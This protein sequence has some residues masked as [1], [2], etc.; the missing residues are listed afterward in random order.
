MNESCV[1]V[2]EKYYE[3]EFDYMTF[4]FALCLFFPEKVEVCTQLSVLPQ[5]ATSQP[6]IQK[7]KSQTTTISTKC[8]DLTIVIDEEMPL[9][10]KPDPVVTVKMVTCWM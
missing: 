7:D 10:S 5:P 3:D 1:V 2:F 4:A 9:I 8:D 6:T